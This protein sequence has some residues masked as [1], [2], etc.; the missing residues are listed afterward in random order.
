MSFIFPDFERLHSERRVKFI[1]IDG[2]ALAYNARDSFLV[3]VDQPASFLNE[4]VNATNP[5]VKTLILHT[6]YQCNLRC[7]HCY[8]KAGEKREDEMDYN[9]LS[10]VVR[11]FGEMGGLGVDLSGG[12]ALLKEGIEDVI[13]TA[14]E[15][16]LRT[17]VL[18]NAAN[19]DPEQLAR[20]SPY[21]DGIA[22]GLDGL[23]EANDKIRGENAFNRTVRGLEMISDSGIELSLTTLITPESIP[24]LTQFPSFISHYGGKSWSLVMPRPSGRFAGEEK[25]IERTYQLWETAKQNGLLRELQTQSKQNGITVVLDHILVPGAKRK[26]EETS[27]DFVYNVYNKGRACWDN[28]LTIMPN[29]DVK[30]CLFFDGQIYDNVKG[31]P[32]REVYESQRRDAAL[33]EF[34]KYPID[35]C[36]FVESE[37][38]RRFSERV[39]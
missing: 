18:S 6:T 10:R 7:K 22:V 8:I 28:T 27:K 15:Q 39:K 36:P 34:R 14:R 23:Q 13:K 25:E 31:K 17:V 1:K 33:A 5:P 30:C 24:Q 2:K 21:L 16:K 11:E 38:L 19:L 35:K 20:I 9:E 32:L 12:E 4:I 37:I 29:G 3:E 26:V